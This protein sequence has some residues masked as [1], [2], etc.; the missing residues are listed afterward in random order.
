M[1]AFGNKDF[2]NIQ[3]Q[4]FK[5]M[6]DIEYILEE[7]GVLNEF[8]IKVVG[9]ETSTAALPNP[10]EYEGDFGDT[11]AIGTEAPYTLYVYT[12]ANDGH[13]NN[14]WFNIGVFPAPGPQGPEGPVGATGSAPVIN[15]YATANGVEAGTPAAVSVSSSGTD[16]NKSF[17]LT[18]DIPQGST[19]LTGPAGPQRNSWTNPEQLEV[20]ALKAILVALMFLLAL[21]RM[22][23][24][25]QLLILFKKTALIM[26]ALK[27][28]IA[29]MFHFI[30]Q[31]AH[32]G[33]MLV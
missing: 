32:N 9:E 30:V 22:L 24:I 17:Y 2:R 12:R 11:Y 33:S 10:T 13:P 29:F 4:V 25:F 6:K 1:L 7:E 21:L 19:G 15:F 14:Y 18:F 27:L 8:G 23:V 31:L 28:H 5:N 26:L 20:R 3:E 16:E